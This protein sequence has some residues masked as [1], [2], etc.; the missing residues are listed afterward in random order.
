MPHPSLKMRAMGARAAVQGLLGDR[1]MA[2]HSSRRVK[3]SSRTR[4]P[5]CSSATP[6]SSYHNHSI[7]DSD[8]LDLW[9]T[10]KELYERAGGVGGGGR[11]RQHINPFKKELQIP[12]ELQASDWAT[13]FEDPDLPLE[14]DVGCGSGRFLLARAKRN[15]KKSNFF[16]MDIRSKLVERSNKWA[17]L[18][19]LGSNLHYYTTNATVSFETVLRSYPGRVDFVSVQYP[20]KLVAPLP[21]RCFPY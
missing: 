7:Q 10:S 11:V 16:G 1:T 2:V 14:V 9:G 13:F 4:S 21:F 18:L 17:E 5:T 12:S 3:V 6:S 19:G 15:G 8:D 20:G